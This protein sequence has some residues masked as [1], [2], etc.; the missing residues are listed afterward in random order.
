MSPH[1]SH[2]QAAGSAVTGGRPR[3]LHRLRAAVRRT[4]SRQGIQELP[5]LARGV[6]LANGALVAGQLAAGHPLMAGASALSLTAIVGALTRRHLVQNEVDREEQD[7]VDR[8]RTGASL[9]DLSPRQHALLDQVL[10]EVAEA[11]GSAMARAIEAT[12]RAQAESE[13]PKAWSLE[14]EGPVPDHAE[15][16]NTAEVDATLRPVQAEDL[17]AMSPVQRRVTDALVADVLSRYPEA[18]VMVPKS[19]GRASP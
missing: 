8:L 14:G 9:D 18:R 11:Q 5:A 10:A 3:A 2:D 4:F 17:A 16:L 15:V 6:L 19:G 12:R 1:A 7:L 13:A